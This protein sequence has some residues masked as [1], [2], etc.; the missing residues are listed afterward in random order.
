MATG[1]RG[2]KKTEPIDLFPQRLRRRTL[3]ASLEATARLSGPGAGRGRASLG[4][5]DLV[6]RAQPC[7]PDPGHGG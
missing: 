7:R 6:R 1:L 4:H 3:E 2:H 5:P